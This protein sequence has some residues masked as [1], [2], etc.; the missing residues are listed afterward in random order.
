MAGFVNDGFEHWLDMMSVKK[1]RACF[2]EGTYLVNLVWDVA[3][4]YLES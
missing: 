1:H 3:K 4:H 2:W